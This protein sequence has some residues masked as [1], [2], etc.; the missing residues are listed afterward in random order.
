[1]EPIS[2]ASMSLKIPGIKKTQ[3]RTR[4]LPAKAK[5]KKMLKNIKKKS[6][7]SKTKL[8]T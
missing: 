4:K 7:S 6:M 8:R 3:R 1:V 2:S 5:A